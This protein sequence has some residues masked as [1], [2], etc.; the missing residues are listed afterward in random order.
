MALLD[1]G[2]TYRDRQ[3]EWDATEAYYS[4]P[5]YVWPLSE[6][7][8]RYHI[9]ERA[10][11]MDGDRWVE[12]CVGG[13]DLVVGVERYF[14]WQMVPL[15]G[16]V[17]EV[18]MARWVGDWRLPLPLPQAQGV[19]DAALVATNPPFSLAIEVVEAAWRHAPHA[20]VCILQRATWYEPTEE[21]GPWLRVH[22]PDQI[23][24]GRCEFFRPDGSSAG[25]GDTCSYTWYVF[26]NSWNRHGPRGGLHEIIPWKEAPRVGA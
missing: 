14:P 16:D 12:P 9:A 17:R 8:R 2:R 6:Y 22:N 3:A 4:R 15:T 11:I 23:T 10:K 25:K 21:R 24:I 5:E 13:G 7:F 19:Q 26:G 1:A 20:L 18:T